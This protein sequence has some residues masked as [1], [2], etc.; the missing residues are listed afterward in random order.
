MIRLST[1]VSWAASFASRATLRR[2][3]SEAASAGGSI[4]TKASAMPKEGY[5]WAGRIMNS[6]RRE[7]ASSRPASVIA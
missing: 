4:E 3:S 1:T 2:S 7:R 5:S 6:R